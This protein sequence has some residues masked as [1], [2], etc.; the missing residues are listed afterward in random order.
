MAGDRCRTLDGYRNL[1]GVE[2]NP[3]KATLLID[4]DVEISPLDLITLS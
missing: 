2:S 1:V 3:P 4:S